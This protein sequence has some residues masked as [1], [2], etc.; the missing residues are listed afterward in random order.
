MGGELGGENSTA[1]EQRLIAS[2]AVHECSL[3]HAKK[4]RVE[5]W[6]ADWPHR[7]GQIISCKVCQPRAPSDRGIG[8]GHLSAALQKQNELKKMEAIQRKF[9][10][11]ECG[12]EKSRDQFWPRGVRNRHHGLAC[13]SCQPTPPEERR[14]RRRP[15]SNATDA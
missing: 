6:E 7:D 10:C 4:P 12:G 9:K 13:K 8:Q 15:A 5:F 11:K 2:K 3:C 1:Q 14:V